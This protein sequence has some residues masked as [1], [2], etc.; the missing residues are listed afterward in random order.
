MAAEQSFVIL[1]VKPY[2]DLCKRGEEKDTAIYGQLNVRVAVSTRVKVMICIWKKK[3]KTRAS[4]ASLLYRFMIQEM[5]QWL[6]LLAF[7]VQQPELTCI[8]FPVTYRN[9]GISHDS[10]SVSPA[11]RY[12]ITV[13]AHRKWERFRHSGRCCTSSCSQ[14]HNCTDKLPSLCFSGFLHIM[15]AEPKS[16]CCTLNTCEQILPIIE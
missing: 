11:S 6:H 8:P 16:T 14:H 7:I 13:T 4:L 5:F 15:N 12:F 1:I 2:L 3:Q 10:E 9:C